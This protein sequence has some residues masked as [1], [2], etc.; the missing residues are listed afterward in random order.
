MEDVII[1]LKGGDLQYC[2]VNASIQAKLLEL[3]VH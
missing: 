2:L 1:K 3:C